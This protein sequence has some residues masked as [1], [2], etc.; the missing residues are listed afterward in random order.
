MRINSE[1]LVKQGFP[2][3]VYVM[4]DTPQPG[5]PILSMQ[6]LY[7]AFSLDRSSLREKWAIRRWGLPL[8][9]QIP[10]RIP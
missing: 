5:E 7:L 6:K 8:H 1:S 4:I 10:A 9:G 3:G 2:S